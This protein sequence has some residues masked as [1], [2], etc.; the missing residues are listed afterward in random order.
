MVQAPALPWVLG[1]VYVPP[2]ER[3]TRWRHRKPCPSVTEIFPR[4]NS[5]AAPRTTC[6]FSGAA[7]AEWV[8][9]HATSPTSYR[10]CPL[11][12]TSLHVDSR[13]R[14]QRSGGGRVGAE[15]GLTFRGGWRYR[16]A[17]CGSMNW[18]ER[19]RRPRRCLVAWSDELG[20][21]AGQSPRFRGHFID[22]M[23]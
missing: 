21:A 6:C 5:R 12:T 9:V 7:V 20:V 14:T 13:R 18:N 10:E 4:S 3:A 11:E 22:I 23:L 17:V 15:N 19:T 2:N 8:V 16:R 1:E